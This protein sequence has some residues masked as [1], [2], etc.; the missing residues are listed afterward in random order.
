MMR[1]TKVVLLSCLVM[2]LLSSAI[3]V[4]ISSKKIEN[5][6]KFVIENSLTNNWGQ[7]YVPGGKIIRVD[8]CNEGL[9]G[10][11]KAYDEEFGVSAA[12]TFNQALGKVTNNDD[13]FSSNMIENK[14][15]LKHRNHQAAGQLKQMDLSACAM[16]TT[17]TEVN[18]IPM[19]KHDGMIRLHIDIEYSMMV[20]TT[21]DF[22]G[23]ITVF[24]QYY[25]DY[26]IDDWSFELNDGIYLEEA[27]SEGFSDTYNFFVDIPSNT[28]CY[29]NIG[30]G[31][32]AGSLQAEDIIG[33]SQ[34]LSDIEVTISF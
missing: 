32:S 10:L 6:Q 28:N 17:H 16:G 4:N 29:L 34:T 24:V 18:F 2:I 12:H 20:T 13:I 23:G 5:I 30:T 9:N 7:I 1:K 26:N 14:I 19:A 31:S 25:D 15:I 21:E 8:D 22:I 33:M 27:G 3:C 11:A